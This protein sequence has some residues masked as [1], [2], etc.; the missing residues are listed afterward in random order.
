MYS[1]GSLWKGVKNPRLAVRELNSLYHTRLGRRGFYP[2][3][4]AVAEEDWDNLIILDACRYDTFEQHHTLDGTLGSRLSR[5]SAT[6]EFLRG[7]FGDGTFHDTVYVSSNPFLEVHDY[8]GTFHDIINVWKEEGWNDEYGTVLPETVNE[9][10]E[11][12]AEQHP[13]KRLIAHF[14]QPHHPFLTDET[15]FDR[16]HAVPDTGIWDRILAGDIDVDRERIRRLYRENLE[17][18]MGPVTELVQELDGKTVVTSDHGNLFGERSFPI[19]V[20]EWGHPGGLY[21]EPLLK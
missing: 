5:G 10:A 17:R 13:E 19:P 15:P 1:L 2:H 18:V 6:P 9:Y 8:S 4:T 14:M 16:R 3:G 21:L 7:N 20:R 11:Q 12:A